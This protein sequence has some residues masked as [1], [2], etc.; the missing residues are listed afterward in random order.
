MTD[1]SPIPTPPTGTAAVRPDIVH[2]AR[3]ELIVDLRANGITATNDN[4]TLYV[5]TRTNPMTRGIFGAYRQGL[6]LE[7][8][9]EPAVGDPDAATTEKARRLLIGLTSFEDI[10]F[11]VNPA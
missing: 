1:T 5:D 2:E 6:E 3:A 7:A 11:E 9:H 4:G 8:A 10:R